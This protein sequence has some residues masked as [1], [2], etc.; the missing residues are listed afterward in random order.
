MN[1]LKISQINI[2]T[3]KNIWAGGLAQVVEHLPSKHYAL[4]TVLVP[5]KG[6]HLRTKKNV[7]VN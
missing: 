7:Q 4:N 2:I 1:H 5:P 6:K 3:K